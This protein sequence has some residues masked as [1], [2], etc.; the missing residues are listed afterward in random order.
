GTSDLISPPI[1]MPAFGTAGQAFLSFMHNYDLEFGTTNAYDGGVLEIKI[2]TNAFTDIVGAGGTFLS[3]PYITNIPTGYSNPL[4]GRA[5]WSGNSG[6]FVSTVVLLPASTSGQTNQFRWRLG[7]DQDHA[8][9]G[10]RVDT[11][12]ITS[13]SCLCCTGTNMAPSLPAQNNRTM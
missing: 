11:V 7:C 4:A 8:N 3:G 5:C 12:S 2:G 9:T 6:G 10:W 13:R 1:V